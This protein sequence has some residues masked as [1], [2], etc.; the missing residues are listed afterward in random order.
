MSRCRSCNRC[1]PGPRCRR[2]GRRTA[3]SSCTA[4][5]GARPVGLAIVEA[6]AVER[7]A[8]TGLAGAAVAVGGD[9]TTGFLGG[10]IAGSGATALAV[11]FLRALAAISTSGQVLS[12]L[13]L[14]VDVEGIR[15]RGD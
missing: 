5:G 12:S 11:A 14:F 7:V 8:G 6:V 10:R 1:Q 3:G 15:C 13:E 9:E 4:V 2:S